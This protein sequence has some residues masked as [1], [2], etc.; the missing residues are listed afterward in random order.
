MQPGRKDCISP[1]RVNL[2]G[3]ETLRQALTCVARELAMK[4][5]S[6]EPVP[7]DRGPSCVWARGGPGWHA[8]AAESMNGDWEGSAG[9]S[10]QAGCPTSLGP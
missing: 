6:L 4:D 3:R 9:R 1:G 10:R 8:R 2:L 7:L 5:R